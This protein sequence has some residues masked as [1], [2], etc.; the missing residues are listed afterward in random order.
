MV[1]F[2]DLRLCAAIAD[3]NAQLA[4]LRDG[5]AAVEAQ[6]ASQ[7]RSAAAAEQAMAAARAETEAQQRTTAA[8]VIAAE[9]VKA[10]A[11]MPSV[12]MLCGSLCGSLSSLTLYLSFPL[13]LFRSRALLVS[14]VGHVLGGESHAEGT[15]GLDGRSVGVIQSRRRNVFKLWYARTT[16]AGRVLSPPHALR[17]WYTDAA[18]SKRIEQLEAVVAKQAAFIERLKSEAEAL[19]PRGGNSRTAQV[20]MCVSVCE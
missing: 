4:A 9:S 12:C 20:C 16:M 2:C 8:I 11:S 3:L 10:S 1:A 14:F 6:L 15:T 18:K 13:C 19:Q 17:L 7:Q 5:K